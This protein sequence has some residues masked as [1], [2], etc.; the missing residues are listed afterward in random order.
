M[1]TNF[2]W[3]PQTRG[4]PAPAP[5]SSRFAPTQLHGCSK[6]KEASGISINELPKAILSQLCF[7]ELYMILKQRKS[8][9]PVAGCCPYLLFW[10]RSSE[11]FLQEIT[12]LGEALG[13]QL[14]V[15]SP[16]TWTTDSFFMGFLEKSG[17]AAKGREGRR[18]RSRMQ[19]K[20]Y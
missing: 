15:T 18:E 20:H 5:R 13:L 17:A 8:H 10:C 1:S 19:L 7:S 14:I 2:V 3:I 9:G 4:S 11:P 12:A 16:P 6:D